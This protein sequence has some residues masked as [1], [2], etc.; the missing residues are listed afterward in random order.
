MAS[1]VR[2]QSAH[3]VHALLLEL[4]V[5]A[6]EFQPHVFELRKQPDDVLQLQLEGT[7]LSQP[8]KQ[9]REASAPAPL[10]LSPPQ[11]QQVQCV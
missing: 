5:R 9:W 7:A 11:Q 10:L 3:S 6:C 2:D 4:L 8:R 1:H